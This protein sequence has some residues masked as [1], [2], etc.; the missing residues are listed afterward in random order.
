MRTPTHGGCARTEPLEPR[1]LLAAQ[2]TDARVAD[3]SDSDL[4]DYSR[5][6]VVVVDLFSDQ[7]QSVF[8]VI[9]EDD[10]GPGDDPI[11]TS[12][13]FDV[14]I[15]G[16][17]LRV[18]IHSDFMNLP[19]DDSLNSIELEINLYDTQTGELL[20]SYD[21]SDDP[22][23]DNL[24]FESGFDDGGLFGQRPDLDS[25][26]LNPNRPL[27]P[28][29]QLTTS[30]RAR[31]LD[32]GGGVTGVYWWIDLNNNSKL[33]AGAEFASL[34]KMDRTSG[35][36]NNG[37]WRAET[38]VPEDFGFGTFRGVVSGW[39]ADGNLAANEYYNL[40]ITGDR[41]PEVT[42]LAISDAVI[43]TGNAFTLTATV[44]DDHGVTA[45][46]FFYDA[47]DD[48]L[49]TPGT[50]TDLG[51]DFNGTDGWSVSPAARA[52]WGSDAQ[53]R[54]VADARDTA[55]QWA[56]T[57]RSVL[58]RLNTRPHAAAWV[59]GN[60]VVT[61]GEVLTVRANANDDTGVAA[62]TFFLDNNRDGQWTPGTDV[63]LGADFDGSDGWSRAWVV[64]QSWVSPGTQVRAV[65][66][67]TDG[68]FGTASAPANVIFNARPVVTGLVASS[69]VISWGQ[70][71]RLTPTVNDPD[72]TIALVT[73]FLDRDANGQWTPG[74]DLD[75]GFDS[76][77]GDGWSLA[78]T[79]RDVWG[80]GVMKFVAG[81]MDNRG[82]W[83]LTGA[84]VEVRVN[85][86]PIITSIV[87]DPV[88]VVSWGQT[89]RLT[90]TA[91][92]N[93]GVS[94]VTFYFDLDR[95]QRFTPGDVDLG[96]D[97]N[98][99]DGWSVSAVVPRWWG[100]GSAAFVAAARDADGAWST[101][102]RSVYVT[103]NDRTQISEFAGV[104]NPVTFGASI[105]LDLR[106]KDKFGVSAVTMFVDLN[107]DGR[108]TAGTDI[109]LGAATRRSG[110]TLDGMWRRTVNATWGHGTFRILADARDSNGV[111]TGA[112]SLLQVVVT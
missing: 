87:S 66:L 52:Q 106:A 8:V 108:W 112:P 100:A 3:R 88:Q 60:G 20:Q 65:A 1:T 33:D 19:G 71:L 57:P 2:I 68:A 80:T 11:Y 104:P 12:E 22:D 82:A 5:T 54:F 36:P 21:A 32:F 14:W 41:P 40:V 73:F 76:F 102:N 23:I 94:V 59:E 84:S 28:G 101:Q 58:S 97:F 34:R 37:T 74:V 105:N 10:G 26:Q 48:G 91:T 15:G 77:G 50:D 67:D 39:D 109:D 92:D 29:E 70:N 25:L 46:T 53:A 45:M 78:Q 96:A 7:N 42:N 81:T 61:V 31:D 63:D 13:P 90:A 107:S 62:V 111:W 99:S 6:G 110:T 17:T 51:A 18:P 89:L 35:S 95:N 9:Q 69:P 79:A 93:L 55:G 56:T 86:P 83:A 16:K 64:Q 30:V 27:T 85:A 49:W 38:T 103:L 47:N 72:G 4:D 75:F 44:S 43:T 98:G 24:F